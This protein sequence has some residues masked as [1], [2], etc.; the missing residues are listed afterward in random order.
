MR[1]T[2]KKS[3]LLCTEHHPVTKMS[4]GKMTQKKIKNKNHDRDRSL[5]LSCEFSHNSY[6]LLLNSE[7]T[8]LMQQSSPCDSGACTSTEPHI[9]HF[10][11]VRL[12]PSNEDKHDWS[13]RANQG[14]RRHRFDAR[15][16]ASWRKISCH[17][18]HFGLQGVEGQKKSF[19]ADLLQAA[20]MFRGW[21]CWTDNSYVGL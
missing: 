8:M 4:S 20:V 18:Y 14:I 15:P 19:L 16:R 7:I 10:N 1:I 6:N 11:N 5:H 2:L 9:K 21:C 3:G 13:R 12:R 17:G